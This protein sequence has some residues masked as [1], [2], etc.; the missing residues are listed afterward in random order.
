MT[1]FS[2]SNSLSS[3]TPCPGVIPHFSKDLQQSF[4]DI[5]YKK[6]E[7][8]STF[9]DQAGITAFAATH[10]G[11]CT[12]YI[13]EQLC[14]YQ[15]NN[16]P[17]FDDLS[18]C[19]STLPIK[20]IYGNFMG[21]YPYDDEIRRQKKL[22]VL[23]VLGTVKSL[24]RLQPF[25]Q[26]HARE[27]LEK[28]LNQKLNLEDFCTRML[29]Y[30]DSHLPGIL[31]LKQKPLTGYFDSDKYHVIIK[32]FLQ[33][34]H[35]ALSKMNKDSLV[36]ASHI[37]DLVRTIIQENA[38]SIIDAPESNI[39]KQYFKIFNIDFHKDSASNLPEDLLKE[40]AVIIMT[41]FETT[42]LSLYWLICYIEENPKVKQRII[43]E[44]S[45]AFSF[46]ESSYIE[47]II[48]ENLRL[49]GANP[50]ALSRQ[51]IQDTTIKYRGVDVP[52]EKGTMLWLDRRKAN[53]DSTVFPCPHQ[54]S[55][56]NIT[57]ILKSDQES[58]FSVFGNKRYEI[59]SF[60]MVNT[61]GNPRKCPGRFFSVM[62]QSTL[63]RE[64]YGS[65]YIHA[66]DTFVDRLRKH[67]VNPKPDNHARIMLTRKLTK[68]QQGQADVHHTIV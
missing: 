8:V 13:G 6:G 36:F 12:F 43:A 39:F 53:Q 48:M 62:V 29:T 5:T 66:E 60:S 21:T 35:D 22:P 45:Q 17:L 38:Q 16:E 9:F 64:I 67:S 19:P 31:D 4:Y 57:A 59:N 51:I 40:L 15:G 23:Q 24:Q 68:N 61:F 52:I 25:V 2:D 42:S 49:A 47:R 3:T 27:F 65:Y 34:A 1:N 11:I 18:L 55:E 7:D 46:K 54:F 32:N 33:I 58:F 37:T 14:L 28:T 44:A 41:I 26:H 50:T 56:N 30:I 10:E 63:I 20:K